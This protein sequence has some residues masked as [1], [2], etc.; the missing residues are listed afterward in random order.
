MEGEYPKLLRLHLDLYKQLQAD[1]LTS[2]VYP[3]A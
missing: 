2:K 1:P 3:D